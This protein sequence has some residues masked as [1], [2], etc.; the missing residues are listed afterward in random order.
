MIDADK[1][2]GELEHILH[3]KEYTVY[4]RNDSMI[5][6]WWNDFND[7]V[8]DQLEKWLPDLSPT[9]STAS[10]VT[11]G[12]LMTIIVI[13]LVILFFVAR[14][15]RHSFQHS[16]NK[17]LQSLNEIQWSSKQHLTEAHRQEQLENY[18]LSIRH[19][20]LALLLHFHEKEWLEAKI[21]KTNWD[22]YDELR[23][24]DQT[25]ADHFFDLA[26]IFDEV[27]YGEKSIDKGEYVE[28]RKRVMKWLMPEQ[29]QNSS[30]IEGG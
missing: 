22:Y 15:M 20:F 10:I 13:F 7:W 2:R 12:L 3:K 1:A 14:R 17:P 6:S 16:M 4:D 18:S 27:T 25:G 19:M 26:L 8:F 23:R 9:S 5:D 21:W 30:R 11:I 29:E 28:Y 24:V